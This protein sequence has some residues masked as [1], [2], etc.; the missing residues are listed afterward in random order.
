MKI[1]VKDGVY[2]DMMKMAICGLKNIQQLTNLLMC[3]TD[4]YM[5][6]LTV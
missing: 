3:L 2:V 1:E 4:L 5:Q 6:Y